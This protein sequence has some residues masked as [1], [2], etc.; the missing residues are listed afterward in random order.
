MIAFLHHPWTR[1]Q[2]AG[3]RRWTAA[4]WDCREW[5]EWARRVSDCRSSSADGAE[6]RCRASRR[7]DHE[8]HR[9]S[10]P[11]DIERHVGWRHWTSAR[12]HWSIPARTIVALR[13]QCC[14]HSDSLWNTAVSCLECDMARIEHAVV[15]WS[16]IRSGD[17]TCRSGNPRD[18]E[19]LVHCTTAEHADCLRRSSAASPSTDRSWR[20][21]H[22]TIMI[23]ASKGWLLLEWSHC[24]SVACCARRCEDGGL[25]GRHS[26]WPW[27]RWTGRATTE[28]RNTCPTREWS[29]PSRSLSGAVALPT[30]L[31]LARDALHASVLIDQQTVT[32]NEPPLHE[33]TPHRQ[34]LDC[35][36]RILPLLC[37]CPSFG[38][39]R[40]RRLPGQGSI[41]STEDHCE[42]GW[43]L[44]WLVGWVWWTRKNYWARKWATSDISHRQ[45]RCHGRWWRRWTPPPSSLIARRRWTD[46]TTETSLPIVFSPLVLAAAWSAELLVSEEIAVDHHVAIGCVER[47]GR[48]ECWARTRGSPRSPRC[49]SNSWIEHRAMNASRRLTCWVVT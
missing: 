4:R 45:T 31:R 1:T 28:T 9:H 17:W 6:R 37:L 40:R 15:S 26:D 33:D 36:P 21:M 47:T 11:P 39:T 32:E 41:I 13:C 12:W 3:W 48:A 10:H 19:V 22:T 35:R 24:R 8:S 18:C 2:R 14:S 30:P 49:R 16:P 43:F 25:V 23:A 29:I 46:T 27:N 42:E 5:T 38:R 7:D 44:L 20:S 34:A